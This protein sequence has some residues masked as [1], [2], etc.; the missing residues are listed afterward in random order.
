MKFQYF[1]ICH[2]F[3]LNE[4]QR[5]SKGNLTLKPLKTKIK[6]QYCH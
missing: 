6:G 2:N 4:Q 3:R 1:L 5:K